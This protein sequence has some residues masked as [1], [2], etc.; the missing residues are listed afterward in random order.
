MGT[1]IG[2]RIYTALNGLQVGEDDQGN[3]YYVERHP[4]EG[5]KRKRWV[6]YKGEREASRVPPEWHG[7]LHYTVDETPEEA[8]VERKPW[9]T[10]H[11][12]QPDRHARGL[13]SAGQRIRR[14]PARR[15]DRRLRAVA[16]VV[17]AG[18]ETVAPR[19]H[20]KPM[21][22]NCRNSTIHRPEP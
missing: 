10:G 18:A 21:P 2:T 17:T 14:R 19:P 22:R 9:Q 15:R 8:P 3:R 1:H 12:A 20:R 11:R 6:I 16:S 4:P 13:A 5:R 7:W